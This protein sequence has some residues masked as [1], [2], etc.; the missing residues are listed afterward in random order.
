M[1]YLLYRDIIGCLGIWDMAGPGSLQVA[2]AFNLVQTATLL[3]LEPDFNVNS[4]S[5][6][7]DSLLYLATQSGHKELVVFV[8]YNSSL[9]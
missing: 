8:G 6:S 1:S 7:Y 2:A 5:H 3:I 4:S 9:E